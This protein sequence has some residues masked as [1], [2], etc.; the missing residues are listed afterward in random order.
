MST[1]VVNQTGKPMDYASLR[2]RQSTYE[3]IRHFIQGEV[4]IK[5]PP[6]KKTM[7]QARLQKRLR[8]LEMCSFE[9]YIDHVF[10]DAGQRERI[11]MIDVITTNKTDFF[12]EPAHYDH[13]LNT[14]L[15]TLESD[16]V[17]D[18]GEPL[19]LWSAGCST[20]E[21]PYTLAMLLQNRHD[22]GR[23]G[24][25][26]ILA[27]DISTR[28]LEMAQTAI[29]PS[30]R[31]AP[32][33]VDLKKKYILRSRDVRRQEVRMGQ[34]LREHVQFKRVNFMDAD[35]GVREK[36]HVIF[37]RNVIIYFDQ[38]LQ[39]SMISKLIRQLRPGGFLYLGHS[40]TLH[41]LGLPLLSVA[42]TVY[43][44]PFN[45]GDRA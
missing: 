45:S 14:A 27:T 3:R 15:K 36:F 18:G 1:A 7:L 32:V 10:S 26:Q 31:I 44:K 13:L 8:A 24:G 34:M 42:P 16:G 4:G 2:M 25:Y 30:A 5:L 21:E 28:V 20:G 12:R 35:Y 33:P 39:R 23:G 40:E 38:T 9:D 6:V 11:H 17:L 43:Q 37:C 22:Q 29:Y 19:K 41:G